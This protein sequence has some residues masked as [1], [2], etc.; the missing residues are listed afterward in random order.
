L[1]ALL[2]VARSLIHAQSAAA[3]LMRPTG[4]SYDAADDLFIADTARNQVFEV[5]VG[6]AISIVAG[7]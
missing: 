7:N 1:L 3:P 5:S 4:V 6:G 2:C